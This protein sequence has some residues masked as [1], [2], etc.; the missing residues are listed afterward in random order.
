MEQ[1]VLKTPVTILFAGSSGC[2]KTQLVK[3]IVSRLEE[4]FDRLPQQIIIC[5]GRNQNAYDKIKNSCRVPVEL[6]QGLPDDLETRRRSLLIIDDLQEHG[7][8]ISDWFTKGSHHSD[9]D[10]IYLTQNLFLKTPGHRT[11]S[12]NAHVLTIFR[13]IRDKSQIHFLSRQLSPENPG[14]IMSAYKQA[15]QRP[16]GYLTINLQQETADHLRVRDSFF[17]MESNFYVDKK[18]VPSFPLS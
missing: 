18:T 14:F 5:Y 7:K 3:K 4:V 17:P 12:L 13:N 10:V 1:Y 2:G 8:L 11:A 9:T 6:V 15:T 16:Y